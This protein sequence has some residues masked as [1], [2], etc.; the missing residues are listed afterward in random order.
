M[1]VSLR[2]GHSILGTL[3]R[4]KHS[5]CATFLQFLDDRG[6]ELLCRII[7][8]VLNGE[9]PLKKVVKST[10]KRRI[11]RHLEQFRRLATPPQ[12]PRDIR[13]KRVI[14]QKGGIVGVI[15]AIASLVAPIL[16]QLIA[17]RSGRRRR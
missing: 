4:L 13:K 11:K 14:L 6:V 7:H 3:K 5:E 8:Y 16:G 15:S 17:S 12:K 10:L 1:S 2:R 9:I